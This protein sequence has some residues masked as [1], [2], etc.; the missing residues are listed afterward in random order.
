MGSKE[1]VQQRQ[2][3]KATLQEANSPVRQINPHLMDHPVQHP[4]TRKRPGL[5]GG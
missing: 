5:C 1:K 3:Q 2:K 4:Q